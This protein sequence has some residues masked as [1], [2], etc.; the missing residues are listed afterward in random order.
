MTNSEVWD[1]FTY[2]ASRI[3]H[4]ASRITHHASRNTFHLSV[5]ITQTCGRFGTRPVTNTQTYL[6]QKCERRKSLVRTD[7]S[8][9]L[10]VKF[11][12]RVPARCESKCRHAAFATVIRW[13][14][15]ASGPACNIR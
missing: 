9:S 5:A 4:H 11:P 3:T 2:H 14:R 1:S 7:H 13:S 10:N 6:C 12:N 15:K 8:K